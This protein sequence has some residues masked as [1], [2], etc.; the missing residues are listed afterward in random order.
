MK[1][2]KKVYLNFQ[3]LLGA[4]DEV[5]VTKRYLWIGELWKDH[6][7]FELSDLYFGWSS[8]Y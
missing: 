6:S 4:R 3:S 7:H 8:G 2:S 1:L 5:A